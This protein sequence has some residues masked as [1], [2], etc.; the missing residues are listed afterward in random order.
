MSKI[1][2]SPA[3]FRNYLLE[4]YIEDENARYEDGSE[5]IWQYDKR[6]NIV[7]PFNPGYGGIRGGRCPSVQKS[8]VV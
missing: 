2:E 5:F 7:E 1:G 4:K 6:M 3:Q 8:I